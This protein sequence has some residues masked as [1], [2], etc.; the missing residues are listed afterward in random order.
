MN[1]AV[2]GLGL[3]GGSFCKALKKNTFHKI[4]G[5]DT[6]KETIKKALECGA[7]FIVSPGFSREIVM[8]CKE[9]NVPVIP[10]CVTPSEIMA[11]LECG[12]DIIKFFPAKEYGG[13]NTMK[14]LAGPFGQIRFMPTG[15]ISLENLKEFISAKFIAACGGTYMVKDNLIEQENYEEIT[16]L[17]KLSTDIVKESR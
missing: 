16:R 8:F 15:G 4:L 1:I 10:G 3:I 13:L 12:V 11:A 17:S 9:N 6:N 7:K 2:V 5:I 14:S